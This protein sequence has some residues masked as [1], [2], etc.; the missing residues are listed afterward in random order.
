[1]KK[2][3]LMLL[4]LFMCGI[5]KNYAQAD[6]K[7]NVA[8]I[9]KNLTDSKVSLKNYE[10]IE[11]TT[12]FLKGEQKS[13]QQKQC[14]YAVDGTLIKVETGV[15]TQ[16][17]QKGGIRGKII[18]KKKEQMSDYAK[19][20]V[21]KIKT[22]LPPDPQKIQRIYENGKTNIQI[23][24]PNTKFKLS[25][26]DYNEPGD[27][28]SISIDKSKQKIISAEV[29]TSIDDPNKKVQ[30]DITYSDLPDGTQYA[31]KTVLDAP[32]KNLK[33]VIENSGFKNAA[34]K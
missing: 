6:V 12:I 25:F 32:E 11:T 28:L 15:S 20:T 29:S 21:S 26:P 17:K 2:L 30:F 9:K 24:K 34:G 10:W 5:A 13:L 7:A 33:I 8:Q 22:Y 14:Y 23:L 31:A 18:E 27:I 1:M 16:T 4:L 3:S 19:L